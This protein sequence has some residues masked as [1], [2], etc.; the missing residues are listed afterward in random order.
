MISR[1]P[2][3]VFDLVIK[4]QNLPTEQQQQV[5]DFVDFLAQKYSNAPQQRSNRILGLQRGMGW[6]SDDFN[7]ALPDEF[8]LGEA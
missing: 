4:L 8:W 5:I 1:S 7:A 6:M 3:L 2:D